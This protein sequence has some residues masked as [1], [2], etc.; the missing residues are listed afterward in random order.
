MTLSGHAW[1]PG[2]EVGHVFLRAP[3]GLAVINASLC[4]QPRAK[5]FAHIRATEI[6]DRLGNVPADR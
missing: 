6:A 2:A 5:R 1:R 3:A 4:R